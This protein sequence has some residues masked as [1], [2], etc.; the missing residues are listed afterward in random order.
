MAKSG[1]SKRDFSG[2]LTHYDRNGRKVGYSERT[3]TEG[4]INYDARGR[5]IGH[6]ERNFS[7]GL[8]HYDLRG[9]E[10]GRSDLNFTDGYTHYNRAGRETGKSSR[11]FGAGFENNMKSSSRGRSGSGGCYIATCVYG[12][13]EAPQVMTLRRFR[14]RWL[15]K[16]PAGRAFIKAY[17]AISPGVVRR[18]GENRLFRRVWRTVLDR[19]VKVL[20]TKGY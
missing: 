12:S 15:A 9:R 18:H 6:S 5:K 14:D 17:Y 1:Y 19:F 7:G 20:K 13:Y 11:T 16:R 10:I 8:T 4:Y 2:N 3:F